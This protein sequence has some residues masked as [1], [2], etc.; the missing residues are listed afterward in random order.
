MYHWRHHHISSYQTFFTTNQVLS[1]LG[2]EKLSLP[3]LWD[4]IQIL[5]KLLENEIYFDGAKIALVEYKAK[6]DNVWAKLGYKVTQEIRLELRCKIANQ[7]S[8]QFEG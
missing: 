6:R 1:W 2:N 5:W 3:T 7:S 4:Q 8:K